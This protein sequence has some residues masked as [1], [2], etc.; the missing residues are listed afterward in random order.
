MRIMRL[1][2]QLVPDALS[3]QRLRLL[4]ALEVLERAGTP[5]ARQVLRSLGQGA[6]GDEVTRQAKASL[7]RLAI[8]PRAVAGSGPTGQPDGLAS[9]K[10]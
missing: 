9:P 10:R 3:P 4:R 5:A 8:R 2:Q 6:E 7:A 1:L